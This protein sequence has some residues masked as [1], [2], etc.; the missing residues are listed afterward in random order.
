MTIVTS[1]TIQ[2]AAIGPA[3][4]ATV[5]PPSRQKPPELSF[6]AVSALK[7]NLVVRQTQMTLA[8]ETREKQQQQQRQTK[9]S[10]WHPKKSN[11][12]R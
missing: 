3:V 6:V 11:K 4:P 2:I 9:T 12:P 8:L 7:A 10:H 5:V 1:A